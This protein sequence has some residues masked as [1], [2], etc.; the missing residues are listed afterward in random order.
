[1]RALRS[2]SAETVF[3]IFAVAF[4]NYL[5]A[6]LVCPEFEGDGDFVGLQPALS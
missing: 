1:M 5:Q 2:W 3:F 4:A 6:A